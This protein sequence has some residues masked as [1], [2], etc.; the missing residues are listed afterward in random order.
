MP[1]V[2]RKGDSTDHGGV[3]LEGFEHQL[4]R[5]AVGRCGAQGFL[6]QM[7]WRLRQRRRKC[8]LQNR[9]YPYCAGGDEDH[10][11]SEPDC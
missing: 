8:R 5:E 9:R 3:V 1:N 2:I 10:M 4:Q 7:Q 11:R 6:P